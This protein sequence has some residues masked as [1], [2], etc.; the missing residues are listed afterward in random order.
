MFSHKDKIHHYQRNHLKHV[1]L[2]LEQHPFLIRVQ[3]QIIQPL[4]NNN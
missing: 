3:I 1:Q 2:R 4:F